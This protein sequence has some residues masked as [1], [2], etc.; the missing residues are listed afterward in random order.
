MKFLPWMLLVVVGFTQ[1]QRDVCPDAEALEP[2]TCDGSGINCMNAKRARELAASFR[3]NGQNEHHGLWIQKTPIRQIR[4]G[5]F[6]RFKFVEVYIEMNENLTNFVVDSLGGSR[7]TLLTLSLFGNALDTFPFE[8]ASEYPELRTLNL[9]KNRLT[10]IPPRAFRAQQ[11]RT[12]ALSHNPI[13]SV[14]RYAF[15]GL[16]RLEKLHL[17]HTRLATLGPYALASASHGIELTI[18]LSD[19]RISYI[20]ATAFQGA[21]PLLLSLERNNLT[22]LAQD[23]FVPLVGN[24]LR[25]MRDR[26]DV[27]AG[28]ILTAGNPLSCRGCDYGWIVKNKRNVFLKRILLDFRCPDGSR[29][30]ELSYTDI[31]C[32]MGGRNR[33]N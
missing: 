28:S 23:A 31:D 8:K 16:P 13:T 21:R 4:S 10:N 6:G 12:L 30:S 17:T 2:C 19:N 27:K 1:A 22:S 18:I 3:A 32:D 7:N 5:I 29:L 9:A 20:D 14:G 11:L 15:S 24:M 26:D 25:N 33:F